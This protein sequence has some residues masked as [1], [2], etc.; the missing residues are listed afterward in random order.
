MMRGDIESNNIMPLLT[1]LN[2]HSGLIIEEGSAQ[3]NLIWPNVIYRLDI[4]HA[5]GDVYMHLGKGQITGI[6]EK[7]NQTMNLGRILTLL[8]VN[9]LFTGGFSD[10]FQDGYSFNK[11]QG[12]LRLHDGK[13]AIKSLNFNGSVA[14][15][16][17]LGD[18]NM[19]THNLN[20]RLAIT[21]YITSSVPVVAG[22]IGGP[23][24]G[25]AAFLA[26]KVLG[27]VVDQIATYRYVVTGG[28]QHPKITKVQQQAA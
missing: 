26:N 20:L 28:W 12:S 9:R 24:I 17:I 18:V 23:V 11:M 13:M 19:L 25:V 10:L 4:Q 2:V 15:I 5:V 21:P 1:A 16:D 3:F 8:S 7:A 22:I 27:K 14:S 6:G